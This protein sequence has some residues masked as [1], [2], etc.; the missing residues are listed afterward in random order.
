MKT[1]VSKVWSIILISFSLNICA[2]DYIPML[3][4]NGR[5]SYVQPKSKSIVIE[6][7]F[8]EAK[9]FSDG[10]AFVKIRSK[11]GAIN[12]QGELVLKPQ[13]SYL[14]QYNNGFIGGVLASNNL[15]E[16]ENITPDTLFNYN[17]KYAPDWDFITQF[18]K[19]NILTDYAII[20]MHSDGKMLIVN[21]NIDVVLELN[22]SVIS[23]ITE[24]TLSKRPTQNE[25]KI[26][27]FSDGFFRIRRQSGKRGDNN[28]YIDYL[29]ISG[30]L[31]IKEPYYDYVSEEGD[32]YHQNINNTNNK[33]GFHDGVALVTKDE[34][35]GYIDTSGNE[36]VPL[37]YSALKL[38]S[39]GQAMFGYENYIN[40]KGIP[41]FPIG[42]DLESVAEF[43][44][45]V[46][47]IKRIENNKSTLIG[48]N[49]K[50]ERL[51]SMP[52]FYNFNGKFSN[53]KLPIYLRDQ[54][55]NESFIIIDKLGKTL[56]KLIYSSMS[57]FSSDG[58][59][60]AKSVGFNESKLYVINCK[61]GKQIIPKKYDKI[62]FITE[63]YKNEIIN[64]LIPKQIDFDLD[65]T[66][67][68]MFINNL[69]LVE[70]LGLQFYIDND[71]FEYVE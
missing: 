1:T 48:I 38:F 61:T 55:G 37:K 29:N 42:S 45:G 21:R 25:L 30:E 65:L 44:D 4:K 57:D 14:T 39:N 31:L 52:Y 64:T 34:Q 15:S 59:A 23:T 58:Y 6:K 68:N 17:K 27:N 62:L 49:P 2:Q 40:K 3:L 32:D 51:F 11:W 18:S 26:S 70:N 41:L 24:G 47:L 20:R 22:K 33:Y 53:G 66:K 16:K 67:F 5:Y 69:I 35:Y 28:E 46:A 54:N 56:Y 63:N 36:V 9:P 10:V 7:E 12:T 13:Y 43:N 50:G 60:I 8:D 19:Q 71:G